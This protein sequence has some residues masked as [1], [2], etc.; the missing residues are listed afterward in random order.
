MVASTSVAFGANQRASAARWRDRSNTLTQELEVSATEAARLRDA[1]HASEESAVELRNDVA[2]LAAERAEA[3]DDA[4][5]A[6]DR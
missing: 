4:T 3:E 6:R 2:R 1:L 5:A